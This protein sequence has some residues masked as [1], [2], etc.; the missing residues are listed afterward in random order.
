MIDYNHMQQQNN[1]SKRTVTFVMSIVFFSIGFLMFLC[2]EFIYIAGNAIPFVPEGIAHTAA[3]LIGSSIIFLIPLFIILRSKSINIRANGLLVLSILFILA[4]G[5]MVINEFGSVLHSS[6]INKS[7]DYALKL[8]SNRLITD[9]KI[10]D[11]IYPDKKYGKNGE[12]LAGISIKYNDY[13]NERKSWNK[14]LDDFNKLCE[15]FNQKSYSDKKLLSKAKKDFT[16]FKAKTDKLINVHEE[17][18]TY[19]DTASKQIIFLRNYESGNLE[20]LKKCAQSE[21]EYTQTQIDNINQ[22]CELSLS[23][24]ELFERLDGHFI[25]KGNNVLFYDQKDVETFNKIANELD[26]L[27]KDQKTWKS[28]YTKKRKSLYNYLN[29][30]TEN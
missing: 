12:I 9:I 18:F 28:E 27:T 14:A 3:K 2:G 5:A 1:N 25:V 21:R 20:K 8:I 15:S 24:V 22:V 11:T 6:S 4:Q 13:L 7:T 23:F 16:S 29:N 26:T 30:I 19:L 10:E 17:F